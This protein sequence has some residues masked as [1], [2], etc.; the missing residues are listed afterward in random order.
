MRFQ[1]VDQALRAAVLRRFAELDHGIP[2]LCVVPDPPKVV[3][4][5]QRAAQGAA[6]ELVRLGNNQQ[7]P[8]PCGRH[9]H[10]TKENK[11]RKAVKPWPTN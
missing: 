1:N 7:Y 11:P 2:S 9:W 10:L 8:Y 3:F 5:D 4:A 6:T